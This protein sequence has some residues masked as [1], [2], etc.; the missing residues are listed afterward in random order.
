M[1][2]VFMIHG[3]YG[4]PEENWLPWLKMQLEKVG[5]EVFVPSFPTPARQTLNNWNKKFSEYAVDKESIL[6]G[7][8]LGAA[9][10]LRYLG[11]NPAKAAFLVA[12]FHDKIG[13][14]ALDF[15]NSSF[16]GPV[17]WENI[18]QNCKHIKSYSST[19]DP[20]INLKTGK[21]LAKNLGIEPTIVE[22]A[23]HF[24]RDA[25]YETF[26]LLLEDI[27]KVLNK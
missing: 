23:G 5:C 12:G 3:V 19:T 14:L 6:V 4:F 11:K 27:K 22:N 16:Y 10:I 24:N 18:K 21:E 1:T 17:N 20:Y 2:K 25:G 15:L 7:H 13:D 8:S 9:F 26:P